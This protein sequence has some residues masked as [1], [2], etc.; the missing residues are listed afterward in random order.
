MVNEKLLEIRFY[1]QIPKGQTGN[2]RGNLRTMAL[3]VCRKRKC[4]NDNE[5]QFVFGGIFGIKKW[6]VTFTIRNR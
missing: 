4:Q 6:A 1:S 3:Q 2:N 5:K